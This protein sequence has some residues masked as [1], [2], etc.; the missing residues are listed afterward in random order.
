M[1]KKPYEAPKLQ[2]REGLAEV[3]AVKKKISEPDRKETL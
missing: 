1:T 2:R 3:T